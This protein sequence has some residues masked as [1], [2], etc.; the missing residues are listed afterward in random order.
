MRFT[1]IYLILLWCYVSIYSEINE[2]EENLQ[3]Q[4]KLAFNA[5]E[6]FSLRGS[7][8]ELVNIFISSGTNYCES[9][10][11]DTLLKNIES[12]RYKRNYNY[13]LTIYLLMFNQ[14]MSTNKEF[15]LSSL[16]NAATISFEQLNNPELY[17]LINKLASIN[18]EKSAEEEIE[19][20]NVYIRKQT[21]YRDILKEHWESKTESKKIR[22]AKMLISLYKENPKTLI[23]TRLCIRIGDIYYT[24]KKNRKMRYWY[25]KAINYSPDISKNTPVGFRLKVSEK[26]IHEEN[27]TIFVYLVYLTSILFTIGYCFVLRKQFDRKVF[28]NKIA[29]ISI[30]F[31]FIAVM[32]FGID[33][34]IIGTD[35]SGLSTKHRSGLT[36][37]LVLLPFW[38]FSN[39]YLLIRVIVSAI[40]PIFMGILL[41]SYKKSSVFIHLPITLMLSYALW[42]HVYVQINSEKNGQL[43]IR[44]NNHLFISGEL[45]DVFLKTPEKVIKATPGFLDYEN[46]DL[47]KFIAENRKNLLKK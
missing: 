31:I 19:R 7:T 20:A 4:L 41:S 17:L 18:G 8:F 44:E 29:W 46:D 24:L 13:L 43:V 36:L 30:I 16:K 15:A 33:H 40:I 5:P 6:Q 26:K 39:L 32:F 34:F 11:L 47:Q 42:L 2:N 27:L 14:S 22:Y 23:N 21:I 35:I 28:E 12:P 1:F 9:I 45:E 25:R 10:N 37:P 38:D 3:S